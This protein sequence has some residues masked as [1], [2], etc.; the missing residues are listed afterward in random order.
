MS[1]PLSATE[2]VCKEVIATL[3]SSSPSTDAQAMKERIEALLPKIAESRKKLMVKS[4]KGRELTAEILKNASKFRNSV[5]ESNGK[6]G[7]GATQQLSILETSVG[8]LEIYWKS[9]EYVTT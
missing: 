4:P 8:K 3:S 6:L 9:F 1:E 5:A 2:S 7:D